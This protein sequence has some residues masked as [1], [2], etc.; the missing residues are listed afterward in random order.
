L[1]KIRSKLAWE[2]LL[3]DNASTDNT[4]DLI[5][6][7]D[8][9]GGRLHYLYAPRQGLGAARD[10]AW[11]NARGKILSFTDDDCYPAVDY[12]DA[13]WDAFER[14]PEGCLGGRILLFDSSDYPITIDEG[15]ECRTLPAKSFIPAGEF[16]G[17]N[18]SFRR[19]VL[20][21]IGGFDRE[22]GAGT[23]FPCEDVDAVAAASWA[24]FE[25]G[26]DPAPVVYH[27]HRRKSRDVPNLR[28]T[29]DRGRGAYFAKYL[30]RKETRATYARAWFAKTLKPSSLLHLGRIY[31]EVSGGL[32]YAL[33]GHSKKRPKVE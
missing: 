11:R 21:T 18:L 13:V 24:G 9:C 29:Y 33:R 5:R 28:A 32:I 10:F 20:E 7:A 19:E 27:H 23:L 16:Q 4:A 3:V 22:L 6:A 2:V 31:R 15:T 30:L 1:A 12:I 26:F 8:D 25:V 17:A 14:R